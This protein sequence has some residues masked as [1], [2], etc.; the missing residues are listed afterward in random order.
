MCTTAVCSV[1]ANDKQRQR[2]CTSERAKA[3][4]ELLGLLDALVGLDKPRE[5]RNPVCPVGG[6]DLA[7][8]WSRQRRQLIKNARI[9]NSNIDDR[10]DYVRIAHGCLDHMRESFDLIAEVFFALSEFDAFRSQLLQ[11]TVRVPYFSPRHPSP[12]PFPSAI[13]SECSTRA[14][15]F[16][17]AA[18]TMV[19]L[20]YTSARSLT[21]S[22]QSMDDC[23]G[24]IN[25]NGV[26]RR[27]VISLIASSSC[28][29]RKT[30]A[31]LLVTRRWRLT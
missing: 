1:F 10:K 9:R 11:R 29:S 24:S 16:G 25:V 6:T 13:A 19:S 20:G 18:N 21:S 8:R 28:Y 14:R 15:G 4:I 30:F 2:L 7:R 12:R 27:V 26:R 5:M 3:Y 23:A 22:C 17:D 31:V